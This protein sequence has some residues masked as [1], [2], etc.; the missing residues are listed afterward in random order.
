[1]GSLQIDVKLNEQNIVQQL[2]V[3]T[4]YNARLSFKQLAKVELRTAEANSEKL[5]WINK[6]T[7]QFPIATPIT[8]LKRQYRMRLFKPLPN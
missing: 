3:D 6:A 8:S 2:C 5:L 1:M 7:D 4:N